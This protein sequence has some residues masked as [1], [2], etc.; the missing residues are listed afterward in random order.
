MRSCHQFI[1][2]MNR[3]RG[4]SFCVKNKE[5]QKRPGKNGNNLSTQIEKKIWRKCWQ[6]KWMLRKKLKS[7][8]KFDL[9][10]TI[11]FHHHVYASQTKRSKKKWWENEQS[12]TNKNTWIK[13]KRTEI[14]RSR[15]GPGATYKVNSKRAIGLWMD[16][17]SAE[18]AFIQ[19]PCISISIVRFGISGETGSVLIS[20]EIWSFQQRIF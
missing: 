6:R 17:S 9:L 18:L 14:R 2:T 11:I 7:N 5:E 15:K 10:K 8:Q 13:K 3:T 4:F 20:N 19:L 1:Y 16:K 12:Q